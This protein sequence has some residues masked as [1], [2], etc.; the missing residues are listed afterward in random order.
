MSEHVRR[1]WPE[2]IDLGDH[3]RKLTE[4]P[5]VVPTVAAAATGSPRPSGDAERG[6]QQFLDLQ[7]YMRRTGRTL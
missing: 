7:A 2:L 6:R 1:L 4:T 3:L 5:V